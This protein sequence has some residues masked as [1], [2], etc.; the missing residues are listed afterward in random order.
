MSALT[1]DRTTGRGKIEISDLAL[2]IANAS[3]VYRGGLVGVTDNG[4]QPMHQYTSGLRFAGVC[5]QGGTGDSGGTINAVVRRTGSWTFAKNTAAASDLYKR[6]YAL[7]DQTVTTTAP[8]GTN[9]A[10]DVGQIIG[11]IDSSTVEVAIQSAFFGGLTVATLL[12]LGGVLK[13]ATVATRG[14][15]TGGTTT[16]NLADVTGTFSQSIINSNFARVTTTLNTLILNLKAAGV[17]A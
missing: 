1:A 9:N 8:T 15:D 13:A 6:A 16:G 2:V 11:I 5:I 3:V 12:N 7:D 14:D 17:V 10:Y 4:L